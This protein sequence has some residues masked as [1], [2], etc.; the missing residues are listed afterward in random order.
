MQFVTAARWSSRRWRRGSSAV[1]KDIDRRWRGQPCLHSFI[2]HDHSAAGDAV[3]ARALDPCAVG[4]GRSR[5][6]MLRVA[7]ARNA[8]NVWSARRAAIGAVHAA[9]GACGLTNGQRSLSR[10]P[11]ST[12]SESPPWRECVTL[13][14]GASPMLTFTHSIGPDVRIRFRIRIGTWCVSSGSSAHASITWDK[15]GWDCSAFC[16]AP[17]RC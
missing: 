12:P 9:M 10:S 13:D 7:A 14:P 16:T 5:V 6:R 3:R 2:V 4:R 17:E 11:P 15:S 1:C 8:G